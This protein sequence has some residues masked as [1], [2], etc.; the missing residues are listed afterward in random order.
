MRLAHLLPLAALVIASAGPAHATACSDDIAAVERRLDSMG[1]A[2]VTG[3]KPAGGVTMSH[4]E[5]ALDRA[6]TLKPGEAGMKPT[7]ERIKEARDLIE[8][9][10]SQDKA[11]DVQACQNT[12]TKVKE[13]A[14]ALP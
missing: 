4:S 11:G 1:A 13:T 2:A 10:R 5:K 3:E 6:P 7:P 8:K 9:A 14:G 12:M